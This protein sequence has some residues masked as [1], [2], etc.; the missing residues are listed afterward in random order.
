VKKKAPAHRVTLLLQS[1]LLLETI[2]AER[3]LRHLEKTQPRLASYLMEAWTPIM[4]LLMRQC[5]TAGAA[6]QIQRR[7]W[8]LILTLLGTAGRA[9]DQAGAREHSAHVRHAA[10]FS[11]K[12]ERRRGGQL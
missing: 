5:E 8:A 1:R 9:S 12:R 11:K 4:Q 7:V 10:T 6:R 3:S 2:G